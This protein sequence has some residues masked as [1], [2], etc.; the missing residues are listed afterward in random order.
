MNR[1]DH[2]SPGSERSKLRDIDLPPT[3]QP[4]RDDVNRLGALVG[5]VIAEQEGEA[6][7][8]EVE[9]LRRAA[10]LRR[11]SG[12]DAGELAAELV[13]RPLPE[14]EAL[15]R[16]FASWF[17]AVN[18]AER[19]HRIRRRRD[20]QKAGATPQPGGLQAVCAALAE[21]GVD[22]EA[23]AALMQRLH[24][25]PVFTAHP[26]EAVRRVL[27]EKE[28]DVVRGLVADIDGSLTP[29]ERATDWARI[30]TALTA[31]WQTSE[32]APEKPTVLDELEHVGFYLTEVLYRVLPTFLATLRE[33]TGVD[34]AG[35]PLLRFGT[36]VGGDMD[37]NPNVGAATMRAALKR[38]Q[39]LLL[40]AYKR[41][42]S[43]LS[44]LLSQSEE[45]IGF[46]DDLMQRIGEYTL[47]FAET[48][49]K[50]NARHRNMPYRQLLRLISARLAA[51][52]RDER[53][54]YEGPE[55]LRADL[56]LIL[57]SLRQHRGQHAGAVEVERL[58]HRVD[59]FGF[60]LATLD[61]RQDSRVH[62]DALSVL[63][64]D[65]EWSSRTVE[66]R[67][68]RLVELLEAAA[69]EWN[70]K[71]ES[72]QSVLDVFRARRELR[73]RYGARA[74]GP[75]IV[76]MSRNSADALAVL[77]LA[78]AG[79]DALP[80][81]S[82]PIDV[83][84]LFETVDD[85]DAAPD[86]LRSL[87]GQPF[88][89]EHLR[90]RG[91]QQMVMLGYSDS[92]K[93]AGLPASRWAI[94]RCQIALGSIA[95]E[96]GICLRFFH[97]RGGS[98]SRGGSKT[99]RAIIAAPRGSVDGYF[100][101]TEQGEVIHRK[102]GI[103]A[104]A[105]RNLEQMSAAV[106]RASL[107]PRPPEPRE[108]VWR[109][110]MES[111]AQEARRVYRAMVHETPEFIP[112]FREATPIDVIERLKL[113]SRP[114]KRAAGGQAGVESLRAIPWVF[115]WSQNRSGFTAWYG[116]GSALKAAIAEHGVEALVEMARDW[117]F[118]GTFIDDI[119]MVL[120]KSDMGIFS[121]YSKL[122]AGHE[123]LF[124]VLNAEFQRTREAILA[125]RGADEL[126][127][128]DR[129]LSLSI[130]LRNPYVDPISLLQVDLLRRWRAAGR[131]EDALFHALVAT[132]NG[133]AAG[134]Q[135]T[136]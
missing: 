3:D 116:A 45:R 104:L 74:F 39:A 101:L 23:F 98:A 76:S 128:G 118:F 47:R 46:N 93:D 54:G 68:T 121:E 7:F 92:A 113:G 42:I 96:A 73:E 40:A 50:A 49:S 65:S 129:R 9:R 136:G 78:K 35:L 11:E 97:G 41:D 66:A 51:T 110:R 22:R 89:R 84:P 109:K 60:H 10:I 114:A 90:R 5:E 87:L 99:E 18:L 67:S 4:L 72:A 20:Y 44:L 19:V 82:I 103:R 52:L 123:A 61:L 38:Q 15:V 58:I 30:R 24:I 8:A 94:Q 127:A 133:I 69:P 55:G 111:L 124:P 63:L 115:A 17:G 31:A 13:G 100:R 88:Y 53:S 70:L 91:E 56:Q 120:A 36:W 14:A 79:G 126:L 122:A 80:D 135:N 112:Y 1:I 83:V 59:A 75:Y 32:D 71:A 64:G 29:Q 125:L 2:D 119:E 132:V 27:L 57:D 34:P 130:R 43:K 108:Q 105:L 25:E 21:E 131:E 86:V 95:A 48:A 62:E 12:E 26:T 106:L 33:A 16:A 77:A 28:R 134:V 102:Y 85:L 37:G 117:P 6:F 81:G 107:R